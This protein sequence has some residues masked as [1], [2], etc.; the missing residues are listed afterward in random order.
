MYIISNYKIQKLGSKVQELIIWIT[1][2]VEVLVLNYDPPLE[3]E[4]PVCPQSVDRMIQQIHLYPACI[5]WWD[6]HM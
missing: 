4:P 1:R 5:C 2:E 6:L 3:T